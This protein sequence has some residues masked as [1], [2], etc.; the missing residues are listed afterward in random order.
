MYLVYRTSDGKAVS[1]GTYVSDPLPADLTAADLTAA[2]FQGLRNG[3]KGWDPITRTV[4]D[5][6]PDSVPIIIAGLETKLRNAIA[7]NQT[8][9]ANVATATANVQG[10]ID[11]TAA[12]IAQANTML[13]TLA[14]TVK[15]MLTQQ[16]R[17]MRQITAIERLLIGSDL[18][19]ENTDT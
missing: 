16:E 12:N 19:V 3:S 2:E 1:I 18:L 15:A 9:L 5:A 8:A 10:V 13:D 17:M 6:P 14:Q 11:D 4:I 7:G